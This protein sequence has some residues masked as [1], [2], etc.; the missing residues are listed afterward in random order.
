MIIGNEVKTPLGKGVLQFKG[1]GFD[2]RYPYSYCYGVRMY[3]NETITD[4]VRQSRTVIGHSSQPLVIFDIDEV[5]D[6]DTT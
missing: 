3:N 6:A 2:P 1:K 4:E 5:E